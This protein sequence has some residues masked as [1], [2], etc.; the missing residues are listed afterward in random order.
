MKRLSWLKIH[1]F[2]LVLFLGLLLFSA[3][4][5]TDSQTIPDEASAMLA[6]KKSLN[7]PDTLGWSDPNY[8]KWKH[9]ACSENRVSRI[10]IGHQ[11]LQGTLPQELSS[12]TQLE[13]LE[14]Q[15]N[16]ISGP[17]PSLKGLSSLQVLILSNNQFSFMPTDFF[18]GMTSLQSVE[19]DVNPFLA[20]EI[21][22][23]LRNASTLQNFSANSANI[24]GTIPEF[25]GP[26]VF[27]GLTNLHLAL[28]NL[29]GELQWVLVGPRSSLCG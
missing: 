19:I 25:L 18:S 13:R 14:V 9:V 11:N 16:N 6:L 27:P 4:L 23:S 21:P 10:Q 5:C 12:L 15:W 20:W 17:L 7:P 28:N 1:G 29:E 2:S 26:D 8:C 3:F 24:T 22:Q